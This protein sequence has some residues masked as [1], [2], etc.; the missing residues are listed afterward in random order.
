MKRPKQTQMTTKEA[1]DVQNG[2]RKT[3]IPLRAKHTLLTKSVS[4]FGRSVNQPNKSLPR[5]FVIPMIDSKNVALLGLTPCDENR[6]EIIQH[7]DDFRNYHFQNVN[8]SKF[9]VD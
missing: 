8:S 9:V 3:L 1:Y 2:T 7:G 5:V 6:K 4:T